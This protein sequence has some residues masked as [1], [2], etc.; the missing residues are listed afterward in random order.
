MWSAIWYILDKMVDHLDFPTVEPIDIEMCKI[1]N[2]YGSSPY[3]DLKTAG[4][5]HANENAIRR[6]YHFSISFVYKG[7]PQIVMVSAKN[8]KQVCASIHLRRGVTGSSVFLETG[9]EGLLAFSRTQD[10]LEE[11]TGHSVPLNR[12]DVLK[13]VLGEQP[14]FRLDSRSIVPH[15]R[16]KWLFNEAHEPYRVA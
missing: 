11:Y 13:Y 4:R 14:A 1:I 12:G 16:G 8:K 15:Q 9:D 5:I 6:D 3:V 10:P 2:A 7:R